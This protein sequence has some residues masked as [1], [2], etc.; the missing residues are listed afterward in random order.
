[1][2]AQDNNTELKKSLGNI[3]G[4][5]G[6]KAFAIIGITFFHMFPDTIQGGYLGVSLFF[7]LSG[8]LLAYSSLNDWKKGTYR[9]RTYYTKCFIT[10]NVLNAFIFL[11]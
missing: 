2:T 9:L 6:L 1:M 7:L 3:R 5:D 8:Y 10:L 4:I 11:W